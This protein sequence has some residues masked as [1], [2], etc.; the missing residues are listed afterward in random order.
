M[1]DAVRWWGTPPLPDHLLSQEEYY[2][3]NNPTEDSIKWI[4]EQM[5]DAAEKLPAISG[6]GQQEA[7]GVRS[8]KHAALAYRGKVGLWYGQKFNDKDIQVSTADTLVVQ[9]RESNKKEF[10]DSKYVKQ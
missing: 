10:F 2:Q 8:S 1:F 5:K 4:L 7:F 9:T 6:K 3:S